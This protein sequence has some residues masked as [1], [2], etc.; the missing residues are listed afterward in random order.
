MTQCK[1][2]S[3]LCLSFIIIFFLFIYDVLSLSPTLSRFLLGSSH[4]S[5]T[6]TSSASN[7]Q[8]A[9]SPVARPRPVPDPQPFTTLAQAQTN[10]SNNKKRTFTDDLHKL[11]DDWAK[12]TH[13]A[14][15]QPRPSL[16]QI[17]QQQ[18]HQDLKGTS[19]Q[20]SG[21]TTQVHSAVFLLNDGSAT[22]RVF[23]FYFIIIIIIQ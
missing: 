9:L 18:R 7:Q 10:N 1:A 20:R 3:V 11:V 14:G 15:P 5:G 8:A 22:A 16:N 4:C 21:G 12:E 6:S 23:Y 19:T 17:K 13:T 2:V